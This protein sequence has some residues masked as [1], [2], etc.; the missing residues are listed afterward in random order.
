MNLR[1]L[2]SSVYPLGDGPESSD[3]Q[4]RLGRVVADTLF[5]AM[6]LIFGGAVALMCY[7]EGLG[8]KLALEMVSLMTV[9]LAILAVYAFEKRLAYPEIFWTAACSAG[10]GLGLIG[11][12]VCALHAPIPKIPIGLLLVLVYAIYRVRNRAPEPPD[13]SSG[14]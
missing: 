13:A 6:L 7:K 8:S 1:W 10:L 11:W 2:F 5:F 14:L 12:A 4:K 3:D 9:M